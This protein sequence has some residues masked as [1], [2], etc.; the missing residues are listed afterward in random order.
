[1]A[2][3][4][5]LLAGISES[6]AD[7]T[8]VISNDL[9][10]IAIPS[11]VKCLGVENDDDVLQLDFKMPRH[12][13]P[14]DLS[15][16]SIRINYMN[17]QGE[18][19]IYTVKNPVV[20]SQYITFSWLVGPIAT[21]YMGDTKFNVCL[22]TFTG[23][24][25]NLTVDRE[26]N[27]TIATLPVLEGLEVDE[28]YLE[29]YS[30]ILEQWRRELFGAGD[31]AV[32]AVEEA[33]QKEQ[34]NIAQKGAEVLATIPEDYQ[35]T[36]KMI[37]NADRTKSDA[38]ICTAEG[39]IVTVS[40][41]SDDY[42]RGLKILGK[43][44]QVKT[45]GK[46]LININQATKT[47]NGI[48]FTP[49]PDGSVHVK[50][51]AVANAYFIFDS[52]NPVPVT[53]TELVASISGSDQVY[54]VVG[55]FTGD[56]SVVNS[57]ASVDDKTT[58]TFTYPATAVT[59]RT[60]LGVDTGKT[61]DATVYPL[62]RLASNPDDSYE[63]YSGG[64]KSPSPDWAQPLNSISNPTVNIYGKNL[65]KLVA[66]N[67]T[68]SGVTFTLNDDNSV[69]IKG[70]ATAS[71]YYGLNYNVLSL[72][73]GEQYTMTGGLPGSS[74]TTY[75]LYAQ[76]IDGKK[77]YAD[78]GN[79]VSFT[80]TDEQW[81]VLFAVYKDTTVD[82]T[83]YP[84]LRLKSVSD[85]AY[86]PYVDQANI[87]V[88]YTLHAIPVTEGGNHT[89][90]NGQQWICDEI[91]FE[92]EVFIK[93][94]GVKVFDGS[95]D[96]NWDVAAKQYYISI[97]DK[98]RNYVEVS[99]ALLCSHFMVAS[100]INTSMGYI[101]ETYWHNGNVNVLINFDDGVGGLDN[102]VTWLQSNPIT[103]HYALATPVETPL[104]AEEIQWFRF[105]HTNFPNTTVINDA[106]ATMQLKYNADT[107]T[108]LKN[109]PKVVVGDSITLK[110]RST[111]KNYT[112]YINNGKLMMDELG[113]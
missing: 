46:Q 39:E 18:G 86:E 33:S 81:Q 3:A 67:Q 6:A 41:S 24:D 80:A 12:I 35:T 92:R 95:T 10:T 87:T 77:F 113:V 73:P 45:T 106:G 19:D 16:F 100:V 20:G 1:M 84:E 36:F 98:R 13:G 99:N 91:D 22:R 49:N 47:N 8:L 11:T 34:E 89:D 38:I 93:R 64:F 82:F 55:Y 61:V 111:D 58:N 75:R 2:T 83:I 108:W 76:T 48:T 28:S 9:R 105:A 74:G 112:L 30:D 70:T 52:N 27:T 85:A 42:L 56:G 14:T 29:S 96:E 72:I 31:S 25:D 78:Y 26:Y 79:G 5:E 44:T 110:D 103:V 68:I 51:T 21:K 62:V 71:I 53:E 59:T 40:D 109:L 17:A 57:I 63:P 66:S 88:P 69:T 50:G 43:T 107:K 104:T 65:L 54:M 97:M 4:E 101:S 94:V 32:S 7:K 90:A 37:D 15:S 102:F 23:S 60:F